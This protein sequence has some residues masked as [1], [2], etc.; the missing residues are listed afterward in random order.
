MLKLCSLVRRVFCLFVLSVM[1]L[2]TTNGTFAQNTTA[3]DDTMVNAGEEKEPKKTSS[4]EKLDARHKLIDSIMLAKHTGKISETEALQK[5][6]SMNIYPVK[7]EDSV[8]ILSN[9]NYCIDLTA[10]LLFRDDNTGYLYAQANFFWN[11]SVYWQA[12]FPSPWPAPPG[13]G[14][15]IGGKDGFGI[16]FN[17]SVT[18]SSSYFYTFD[19]SGEHYQTTY[20]TKKTIYGVG[21]TDY[22]YGFKNSDGTYDYTWDSGFISVY[23]STAS[24]TG[25]AAWSEM[26]HTWSTSS[27]TIT[28]ISY[29]AGITW[30]Y[31][32]Y[33]YNWDICGPT[34][35]YQIL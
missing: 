16:V 3:L 24:T 29:P 14:V 31:N 27:V 9:P 21:Y 19:T 23:F 6:A 34:G 30:Q 8:A 15:Q 7:T 26:S 33:T 4:Q 28:G 17:K 32:N 2:V 18:I 35:Y 11:G 20:P 25:L 1:L 12:D 13:V 10:P 22:D 5:L